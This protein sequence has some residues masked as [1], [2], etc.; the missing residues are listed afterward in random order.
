MATWSSAKQWLGNPQAPAISVSLP[1]QPR[2]FSRRQ[3]CPFFAGLLP[4]EAQHAAAARAV[5][6]SDGNDFAL[7]DAL[8][9]DV[10]GALTLLPQGMAPTDYKRPFEP[11]LLDD[12][13]LE[14]LLDDLSRRP[15]LAGE[16]GLRLSHDAKTARKSR[17]R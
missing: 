15:L 2:A 13:A 8:G 5:G 6:V 4:D 7:L 11:R 16:E 1:K 10:A 14:A 17:L 12:A 9:G 3:T